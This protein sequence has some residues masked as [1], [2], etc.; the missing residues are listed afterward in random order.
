MH[1]LAITQSI[2]AAVTEHVGKSKV[3][4]VV[5]EVGALTTV[6]PHAVRF[7]FDVCAKDTNLAGAELEI[8]EIAGRARCMDC[9]DERALESPIALC[10]CG[11]L[12]FDLLSGHELKIR[13]VEVL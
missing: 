11:S 1:E 6:A 8:V 7:C 3:T 13:E 9:G 5:I 4:R 10:P 2:I 12:N